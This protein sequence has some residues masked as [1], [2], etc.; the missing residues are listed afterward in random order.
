MKIES[1]KRHLGRYSIQQRR[2]TTLNH[3][4]A[5]AIAP[6]E[7]YDSERIIEAMAVLGQSDKSNLTC[8]YCGQAAQTWDHLR[9]L[10]RNKV[11]SGYG[12]TLGNLVPSCR[13]CNSKKG[14][15]DWLEWARLV[16]VSEEQIRRIGLYVEVY[17]PPPLPWEALKASFPDLM[18]VYESKLAAIKSAMKEAD[19]IARK[20]V[21]L[22]R[23]RHD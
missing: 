6:T 8:V 4:F 22:R 20:I 13:D 2:E 19:L 12:H 5:S 15:K 23:A 17:T 16:S 3:A 9:P 7:S 21:E 14:N 11:T 18:K 10:V 1:L